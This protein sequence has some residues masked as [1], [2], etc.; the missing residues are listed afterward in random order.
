M[1][2]GKI[3][4]TDPQTN[5]IRDIDQTLANCTPKK[6]E[7]WLMRVDNRELTALVDDAVEDII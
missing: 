3:V 2:N 1:E 6:G 7:I 5:K 4:Y